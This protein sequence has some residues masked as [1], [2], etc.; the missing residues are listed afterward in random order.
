ML[1]VHNK[2]LGKTKVGIRDFRSN[3]SGF[4]RRAHNGE[5]IVLTS[6]NK[7]VAELHSA[8]PTK[9]QARRK[10][11]VLKGRIKVAP[12]FDTLPDEMIKAFEG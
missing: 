12:D 4:L 10:P 11:G 7:A 2:K 3:L 5:I 1:G 6:H 8:T 9:Q